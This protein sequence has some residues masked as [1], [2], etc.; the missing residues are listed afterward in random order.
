[1]IKETLDTGLGLSVSAGFDV[2]NRPRHVIRSILPDG[3]AHRSGQLKAGDELVEVNTKVLLGRAHQEVVD[4]LRELPK[5][6][7]LVVARIKPEQPGSPVPHPKIH[8]LEQ[9]DSPLDLVTS[10]TNT[11]LST[12]ILAIAAKDEPIDEKTENLS[13]STSS[14]SQNLGLEVVKPDSANSSRTTSFHGE[15]NFS[16]DL[17][18][19]YKSIEQYYY[20]T[21]P[22]ATVAVP[23]PSAT[24]SFESSL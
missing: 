7:T 11:M 12:E 15:I 13:S 20:E 19:T 2:E 21:T 6:V 4:I 9:N 14:L 24:K 8:N 18:S 17:Q 10:R 22:E 1:M 23:S 16:T 3:P 5:N